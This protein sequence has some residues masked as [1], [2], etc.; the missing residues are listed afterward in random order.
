[1]YYKIINTESEVYKKLHELRTRELQ[2][3]EENEKAVIEKIGFE[4]DSFMGS[5]S[6]QTWNRVTRYTGFKPK[7]KQEIDM[8]IWNK[9]PDDKSYLVPNKRTKKGR[10][11]AEFLLNGLKG[12]RYDKVFEILLDKDHHRRFT[13]PYVDIVDGIILIY[14]D[15]NHEPAD[16]ENVIEITKKEFEELNKSTD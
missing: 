8:T 11:I 4:Y 1:M 2:I 12:S 9:D 7:P 5:N 13:F 6:Q 16:T 14:M 15:E 10:E 3:I